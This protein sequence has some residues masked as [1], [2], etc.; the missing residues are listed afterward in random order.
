MKELEELGLTRN[1]AR[2]YSALLDL[3][4]SKA[5]RTAKECGLDRSSAY[6][7]LNGLLAK[8]L[9]S[10]AVIGRVKWFQAANPQQFRERAREQLALAEKIVPQLTEKFD[11]KKLESNMRLFKGRKGVKTVLEDV[12]RNARKNRMF[13]SEGQLGEEMPVFAK[14]FV[15]RLEKKGVKV[16]SIVRKGRGIRNARHREVRCIPMERDSPVVTNI[17]RNKIAIIVWGREPEAILIENKKAALAYKDFFEFVW[18]H[19][20]KDSTK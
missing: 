20:E 16:Q 10:Y 14:K 19:A 7:A 17:Y 13:G 6:N 8:G 3:G 12:L 18:K 4:S 1:E 5:G 2:V 15:A 9:A 11:A